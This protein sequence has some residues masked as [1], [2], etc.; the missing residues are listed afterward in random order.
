[1]LVTVTV[2]V[3]EDPA[4]KL[5]LVGLTAT[6]KSP[7][8]RDTDAVATNVVEAPD[9]GVTGFEENDVLTPEGA[10]ES[11]SVAAELKPFID[12]IVMVE[13]PEL[14]CSIDREFGEA[15]MEK[16][17]VGTVRFIEVE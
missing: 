8:I 9:G 14:P 6:L 2:A 7:M 11:D 12:V 1:M 3:E 15:D 4:A 5:I 10:P 16:S 13:V 17:G